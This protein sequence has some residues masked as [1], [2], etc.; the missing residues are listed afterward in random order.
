[1]DHLALRETRHNPTTFP[2]HAVPAKPP[3]SRPKL[4]D[5]ESHCTYLQS[6]DGIFTE[7]EVLNALDQ[8][9]GDKAPGP[10]G[11]TFNFYK[12][13][14]SIIKADDMAFF[15][16]FHG[17]RMSNLHLINSASIILV[18]KKEGAARMQDYIPISL[19]HGL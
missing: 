7:N 18:P 6:L 5:F 15:H 4:G 11:F 10:E 1:M 12:S 13:C 9:P 14:W 8:L 2:G 19:I 17:L 16:S 3:N